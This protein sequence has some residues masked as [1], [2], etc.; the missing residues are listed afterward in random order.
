MKKPVVFV[1][2]GICGLIFG[3]NSEE[4]EPGISTIKNTS[5]NFDV[6]YQFKDNLERTIAKGAEDSFERPLYDYI[7]SYEPSKRVSLNTQ[8]PYK[9]D[10]VYTFSERQSYTVKVRNTTGEKVNL[11]ADGWMNDMN[12]IQTDDTEHTEKIYTN[13]PN[14]K[15]TTE[16]GFPA[17]VDYN[18]I[19]GKCMVV[20]K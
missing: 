5:E 7:K 18:F 8:Y 9:N 17:E 16:S 4:Q 19:D 1:I 20:I 12:D 11:S 13:T 10:A 3:C 6:T 2:I 14:F 15:V